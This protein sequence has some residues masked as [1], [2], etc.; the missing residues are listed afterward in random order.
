MSWSLDLLAASASSPFMDMLA[1][2]LIPSACAGGPCQLCDLYQL[3]HNIIKLL[4]QIAVPLA[5]AFLFYGGFLY[6]TSG[7]NPGNLEKGKKSITNAA[8]GLLIAFGAYAIITSFLLIVGFDMP[9]SDAI[10]VW[11]EFPKCERYDPLTL[12]KQCGGTTSGFCAAGSQCQQ[13]ADGMFGCVAV[14]LDEGPECGEVFG[15]CPNSQRC[16]APGGGGAY[17]CETFTDASTMAEDEARGVLAADHIGVNTTCDTA[18]N[19]GTC[20]GNVK[21]ETMT[22]LRAFNEACAAAVGSSCNLVVTGASEFGGTSG[23]HSGTVDTPGSHPAGD[24]IDLGLNTR[25]NAYIENNF[26]RMSSCPRNGAASSCYY[27]P[28]NSG[29]IYYREGNH[30]DVCYANCR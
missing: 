29:N 25:V 6:I 15:W 20:F 17:I 22:D 13:G 9:T 16:V 2:G 8:I 3:A 27:D 19:R 23:D 30:W 24:K 14:P 7:A 11:S 26:V 5:I 10:K 21:G 4:L 1:Q 28:G 12:I 18:A